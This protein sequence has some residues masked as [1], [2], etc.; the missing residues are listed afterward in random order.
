VSLFAGVVFECPGCGERL[1][2]ESRC[3]DCNLFCRRLG[4]GGC[5][6]GCGEMVTVEELG[7]PL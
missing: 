6:P 7:G 2:G 3:P 5:C 4:R 1:V